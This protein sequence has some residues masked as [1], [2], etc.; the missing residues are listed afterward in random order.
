MWS[1]YELT[2]GRPL[3]NI[4]DL[5]SKMSVVVSYLS[6]AVAFAALLP[7]LLSPKEYGTLQVMNF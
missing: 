5:E 4:A 1:L 7:W 6:S 3:E 2:V